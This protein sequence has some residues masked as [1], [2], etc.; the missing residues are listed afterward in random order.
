MYSQ[1]VATR[2]IKIQVLDAQRPTSNC[3][4]R[5]ITIGSGCGILKTGLASFKKWRVSHEQVEESIDTW[6]KVTWLMV[7]RF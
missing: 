6:W 2:Q 5:G 1:A 4:A 7:R 3:S